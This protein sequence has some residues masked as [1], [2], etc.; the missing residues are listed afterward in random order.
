[1]VTGGRKEK[2]RTLK[3]RGCGTRRSGIRENGVPGAAYGGEGDVVDFGVGAP[4]GAGGDGDFEFAWEIVEVGI[5][6]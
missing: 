6:A 3:I 5:A 2:T 1:M 4:V